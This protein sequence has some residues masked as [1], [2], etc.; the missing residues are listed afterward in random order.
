[1]YTPE[2]LTS[3][4]TTTMESTDKANNNIWKCQFLLV[5]CKI[6]TPD[7]H[8]SGRFLEVDKLARN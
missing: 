7:M 4:I 3:T 2:T 8:K 1:M 5:L 6:V